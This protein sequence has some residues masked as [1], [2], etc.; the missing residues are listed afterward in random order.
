MSR[1]KPRVDP[2]NVQP[3]GMTFCSAGEVRTSGYAIHKS[4]KGW[5][6]DIIVVVVGILSGIIQRG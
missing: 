6:I 5:Y 4:K 3:V 2:R 1:L